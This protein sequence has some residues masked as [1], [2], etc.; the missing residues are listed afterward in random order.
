MLNRNIM[1]DNKCIKPFRGGQSRDVTVDFLKGWAMLSIVIFH[2]STSLIPEWLAN[3]MM[4][5][6]NVAVFFIVAGYYLKWEKMINPVPFI[7]GKLKTLYIPATVIYLCAVLSHNLFVNIGWYPLGGLHPAT[8]VPFIHY[9]L[10]EIVLGCGKVLL[11]A[12]SGELVMGAMWFLYTL[13]YS[14]VG[15]SLLAWI[16]NKFIKDAIK[17]QWIVFLILLLGVVVSCIF[18]Q[19]LGFTINRVNVAITAMFLINIGRLV[20]QR[21]KVAFDNPWMMAV[22]LLTFIQCFILSHVQLTMAKNDFQDIGWLVLGSLSVIYV[23]TFLAKRIEKSFFVNCISRIGKDSFY[24]MALHI[25]GF[26]CCNSLLVE[27]GVFEE[28]SEKGLYTFMYGKNIII[29]FLYTICGIGLPLSVVYLK[30]K[31]KGI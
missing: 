2:Q 30:N 18:T 25:L 12:G 17:Q 9:G 31:I 14:M 1:T 15:L 28:T 5:P 27:F 29:F 13:I 8:G 4:N 3:L 26:F 11:C 20:K 10:K 22:C 23:Y 6:W 21:L 7:K 19:K 16:V 24:V